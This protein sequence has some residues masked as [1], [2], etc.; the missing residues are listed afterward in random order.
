MLQLLYMQRLFYFKIRFIMSKFN[1]GN[2]LS[3][4]GISALSQGE[5]ALKSGKKYRLFPEK[6][7]NTGF[8]FSGGKE[9]NN[10]VK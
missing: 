8:K 10:K 9:N 3:N 2:N 4:F 1:I 5:K 7:N 6:K